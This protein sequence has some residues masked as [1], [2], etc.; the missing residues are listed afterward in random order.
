MKNNK[1]KKLPSKITYGKKYALAM[2]I[3]NEKDAQQY[4][5]RLVEHTMSKGKTRT[6][7]EVIERENLGYYAGYYNNQT[8]LRVERL[9]D[10]KHPI[11]GKAS[12]GIPTAKEAF[13]KGINS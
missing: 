4:F 3:T 13:E 2:E 5:E 1:F 12:E 9:F 7:A 6:E 8:R 11:F 10:C